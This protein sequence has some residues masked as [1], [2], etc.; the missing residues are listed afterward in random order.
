MRK[1]TPLADQFDWWKRTVAGERVPHIEDE[2]QS[3][4]FYVRYVKNGPK[5]PVR[6]Y[7]HQVV[8]PETGELEEPERY[9]ARFNDGR[10]IPASQ[11]WLYARAI[12]LDEFKGLVAFV[13]AN[14]SVEVATHAPLDH[15]TLSFRPP[16][17]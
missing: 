12:S 16:R 13:N 1:P 9:I 10:E 14:A 7:L 11:I 8:D 6:I 17:R 5:L 15:S 2:P 4:Y 3:G